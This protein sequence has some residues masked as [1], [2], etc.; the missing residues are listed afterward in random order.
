MTP[1]FIEELEEEEQAKEE[2]YNAIGEIYNLYKD[3]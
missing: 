2:K 1:A 3:L